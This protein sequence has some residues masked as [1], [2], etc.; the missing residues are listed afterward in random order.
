MAKH[1][2]ELV[3]RALQRYAV[4]NGDVLPHG[5]LEHICWFQE[6]NLHITFPGEA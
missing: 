2:I 5:P 1:P 6:D 3:G 4:R